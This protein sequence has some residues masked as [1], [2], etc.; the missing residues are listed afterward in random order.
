MHFLLNTIIELNNAQW[1]N[2]IIQKYLN[3]Y[4]FIVFALNH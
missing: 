3:A 1:N 4:M 2:E